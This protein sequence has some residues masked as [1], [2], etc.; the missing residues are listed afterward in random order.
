MRKILLTLTTLLLGAAPVLATGGLS[1]TFKDRNVSF[2][3]EA[4]FS[5]GVGEGFVSFSSKL[6]V[7]AKAMPDDLRK[8]QLELEHLTQRWL[9]G[10]ELKL[11]LYHERS[12]PG[13][14]GYVEMVVETKQSAKEETDYRGTYVLTAYHIPS[15][16]ADGKTITLRGRAACSLG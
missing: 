1:C 14:H 5:R 3:A 12:G 15:E 7:L 16:G 9:Y 10:K 11:R 13:L 2:D 8:L 6:E 4:T